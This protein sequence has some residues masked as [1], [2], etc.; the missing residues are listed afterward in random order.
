MRGRVCLVT[1]ATGGIG[2]ATACGLA[3]QGATVVIAG[4]SLERGRAAVERIKAEGG[5]DA[6]FLLADLSSQPDV[7]RLAEEFSRRHA[8]LHVLVNNVGGLFLNGQ[9]SPDGVEMTLALNHLGPYLLT[10]LLRDVLIASAPSRVVNV[11]SLAHLGA[12]LE[13]PDLRF[14]GWR[15]YKRSKLANVLFTYELARRLEGTGVTANALSPG[16]VA[17]DFGRNNR[18]PFRLVRPLVYAF[19]P[20][21]E[22]GARTSV[23]LAAAPD[24]EGVTGKYFT[25]CQPRRSSR[26]SYDRA[27]QARL[28]E[29][30]A[31][32][33]GLPAD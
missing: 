24:L 7:R 8:S 11:S 32:L 23:H 3:R 9:R 4:R 30:S 10:R 14:A 12:R 25:R 17:S 2:L 28:W 29:L 27:A 13:L 21:C 26:A 6:E 33:T 31:S 16:L 1:G 20:G 15:G 18:G 19:A 22:S 5:P